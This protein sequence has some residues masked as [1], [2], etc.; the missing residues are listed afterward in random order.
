M[1]YQGKRKHGRDSGELA[2]DTENEEPA[3]CLR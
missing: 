1:K 2:N 3:A